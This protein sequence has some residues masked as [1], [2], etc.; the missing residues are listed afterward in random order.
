MFINGIDSKWAET[1]QT[2]KKPRLDSYNGDPS[3]PNGI[4][5]RIVSSMFDIYD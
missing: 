1:N 5:L 2:I 4:D 3:I